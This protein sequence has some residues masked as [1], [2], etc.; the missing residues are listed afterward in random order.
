MSRMVCQ[1]LPTREK[2]LVRGPDPVEV[3]DGGQLGAVRG[4]GR[5]QTGPRTL[6]GTT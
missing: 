3:W 2:D 6:A 5:R 4:T 1:A